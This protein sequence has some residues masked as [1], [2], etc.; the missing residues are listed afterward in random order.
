MTQELEN[1]TI[2]TV[3]EA[4]RTQKGKKP[5]DSG[6]PSDERIVPYINIKAF[7]SGKPASAA[8]LL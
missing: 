5:K 8:C 4:C 6:T 3:A 2:T 1:W 7:E